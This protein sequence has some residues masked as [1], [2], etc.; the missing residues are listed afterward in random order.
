MK[1]PTKSS[2]SDIADTYSYRLKRVYWF[3]CKILPDWKISQQMFQR[4]EIGA[5]PG[6]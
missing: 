3:I 6:S 5:F 4:T 2:F 1:K